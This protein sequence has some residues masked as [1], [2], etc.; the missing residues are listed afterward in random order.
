M[1]IFRIQHTNPVLNKCIPTKWKVAGWVTR[2]ESHDDQNF[3]SQLIDD[4]AMTATVGWCTL[5][6]SNWKLVTFI[7]RKCFNFRAPCS[8]GSCL[9]VS[10]SL[11]LPSLRPPRFASRPTQHHRRACAMS[12]F[13]G[14]TPSLLKTPLSPII[15]Q[16]LC[17]RINKDA[18]P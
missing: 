8:A 4:V 11:Q 7:D 2:S 14:N 12:A 6:K 15:I 10:S 3:K 13:Y 9:R 16:S 18:T 1:S 17:Y 5:L